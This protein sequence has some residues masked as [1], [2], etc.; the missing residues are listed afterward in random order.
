[1]ESNVNYTL[2][3]LFVVVLGAAALAVI[4]WLSAAT[5]QRVYD[6]YRV[7]SIES[8]S[9]LNVNAAVRYKGVDV[10]QV[11]SIKLDKQFPDWVEL[12]LRIERGTPIREDTTAKLVVQGI[13]GLVYVELSGGTDTP[14]L[15]PTADEP[16]PIIKTSPSLVAQVTSAFQ[17]LTVKVDRLL[18]NDNLSAVSQTLANLA[19]LSQSLA[20]R[21]QSI[22][23]TVANL[24]KFTG[25]LVAS[26]DKLNQA[27]DN[28]AGILANSAQA[29]AELKPLLGQVN[30][31]F[32]DADTMVNSVTQ[33]SEALRLAFVRSLQDLQKLTRSATP[34]LP[35]LLYDLNRLANAL[36][37]FVQALERNP[38]MLLFGKPTNEPG[39]GEK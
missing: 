13:T 16:M 6:S 11:T 7:Y 18:S 20:G 30:K 10:G 2:A 36:E 31:T 37:R 9:G 23:Q 17:D 15:L 24:E 25:S 5:D 34:E 1:M 19:T 26:S 33:T 14:P 28:T 27:I 32:V 4:A 22:D 3:G 38:R 21:A 35:V 39:P 8:V 29:T 12:I